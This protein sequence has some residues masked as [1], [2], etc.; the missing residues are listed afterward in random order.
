MFDDALGWA[1]EVLGHDI[2][3]VEELTG[4]LSATMP[5][6]TDTSG[7]RSVLRLIDR[8]PWQSPGHVMVANEQKAQR[9]LVNSPVPVPASLALDADGTRTGCPAH[10]MTWVPGVPTGPVHDAV[11]ATMAEMLVTIH[12]IRPSAPF[13]TYQS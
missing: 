2:S 7:S 11:L 9:E 13:R 10:L 3:R 12:A 8:E 4:G 5:S 6:L 1:A